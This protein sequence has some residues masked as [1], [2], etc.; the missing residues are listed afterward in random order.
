LQRKGNTFDSILRFGGVEGGEW[1]SKPGAGYA[2]HVRLEVA[3]DLEQ[4]ETYF[5]LQSG[6]HCLSDR[7]G[8]HWSE[9][10]AEIR[11]KLNSRTVSP[12]D[13]VRRETVGAANPFALAAIETVVGRSGSRSISAST[14]EKEFGE[15]LATL[16]DPTQ[17]DLLYP[18]LRVENHK[19][20]LHHICPDSPDT[21]QWVNSGRFFTEAVRFTDPI[22]GGLADCYFIA[23]LA[24]TACACPLVISKGSATTGRQGESANTAATD[25]ISFFDSTGRHLVSPSELLPR[26]NGCWLY[27]RADDPDQLWPG[28]YEKAF[29]VWKTGTASEQPDMT[30]INYGDTVA[31]GVALT[32]GS[33]SYFPT[34]ESV[35]LP[36]VGSIDCVTADQIWQTVRAHSLGMRAVHPMMAWTPGSA[37]AGL[38]YGSAHIVLNH[39]YSILG[40]DYQNGTEYI[41]LR[42]PWGTYEATL[43]VLSGTWTAFD[44]ASWRGTTLSTAGVFAITAKTFKQYFEGFGAVVLPAGAQ[45][46]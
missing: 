3:T 40:W 22:Q 34:S 2:D 26:L 16:T 41:V 42:N 23:A 12:N 43:D 46:C 30:Q 31:A 7:I 4:D 32:N 1:M 18:G 9:V 28:V 38:D 36:F 25:A 5:P 13:S 21:T 27:A 29:A 19:V 6:L 14:V 44:G 11:R 17:S 15:D 20:R 10:P 39:A 33:G 35:D 37:P 8:H 45:D 24:S